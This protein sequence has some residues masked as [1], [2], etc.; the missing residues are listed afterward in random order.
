MPRILRL[1]SDVRT[2]GPE[3]RGRS[4]RPQHKPDAARTGQGT[5]LQLRLDLQVPV[6]DGMQATAAL[7]ARGCE[8]PIIALTAN[9]MADGRET[10]LRDG[11]DEYICKPVERSTLI[12]ILADFLASRVRNAA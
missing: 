12:R 9:T 8:T 10:C 3:E 4:L 7:R 5:C 1:L 6:L 11:F 2:G